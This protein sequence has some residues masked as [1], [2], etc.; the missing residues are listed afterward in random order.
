MAFIPIESKGNILT[1]LWNSGN[2]AKCKNFRRNLKGGGVRRGEKI[3][4]EIETLN[5][6]QNI[7]IAPH[8]QQ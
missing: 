6:E 7:S 2:D 5:E 8:Y 4:S 1:V 3:V